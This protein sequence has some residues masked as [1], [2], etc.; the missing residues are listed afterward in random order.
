MQEP[1][2]FLFHYFPQPP[3]STCPAKLVFGGQGPLPMRAFGAEKAGAPLGTARPVA[4]FAR[5][6]EFGKL[7]FVEYVT[8]ENVGAI[9]DR[10]RGIVLRIRRKPMR[11]RKHL[12][13]GRSMSAPTYSIEHSKRNRI[14]HAERILATSRECPKDGI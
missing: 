14:P 2:R 4:S 8:I 7:G 5:H 6:T 3:A 1:C 11:I 13:A 9:I 10:P 12:C